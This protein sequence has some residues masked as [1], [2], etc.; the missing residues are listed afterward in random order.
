VS[1]F[2]AMKITLLI[3]IAWSYSCHS[4][5][6]N[7]VEFSERIFSSHV[8]WVKASDDDRPKYCDVLSLYLLDTVL[9]VDAL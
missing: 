9:H 6:N 2:Y 7:Y 1:T 8:T 5:L 4:I 3:M